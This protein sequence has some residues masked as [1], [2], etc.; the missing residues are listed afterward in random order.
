LRDSRDLPAG[1]IRKHLRLACRDRVE[2]TIRTKRLA[3][4]PLRVLDEYAHLPIKPDLVSLA[5]RNVAEK[6]FALRV[7][8]GS[9]GEAVP[10]AHELPALAGNK[11]I[12]QRLIL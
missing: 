11:N 7:C 6:H 4:A 9:L 10:F 2:T 5:C 12:V 8:S 3:I 1:I